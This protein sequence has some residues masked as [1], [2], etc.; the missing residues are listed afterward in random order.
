M[1][2]V[3]GDFGTV[4]PLVPWVSFFGETKYNRILTIPHIL[5][6][7]EGFSTESSK[8]ADYDCDT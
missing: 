6:H 5:F 7:C 8:H 3:E 1:V 2:Q 4:H